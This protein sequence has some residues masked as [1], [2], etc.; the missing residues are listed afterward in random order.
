M[1]VCE[2]PYNAPLPCCPSIHCLPLRIFHVLIVK[3]CRFPRGGKVAQRPALLFG[4]LPK[5][6]MQVCLNCAAPRTL[7]CAL[8]A[9]IYVVIIGTIL[10]MLFSDA[11]QCEAVQ[12]LC[13]TLS[14]LFSLVLV[15]C[16]VHTSMKGTASPAIVSLR[17]PQPPACHHR[18]LLCQL[19]SKQ[20]DVRALVKLPR[21]LYSFHLPR[22]CYCGCVIYA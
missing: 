2:C 22:N 5:N 20:A 19:A 4:H 16:C 14:C 6:V 7:A 15:L 17:T 21:C 18:R 11:Y 3:H 1:V 12:H 10:L 13:C 9:D 8:I